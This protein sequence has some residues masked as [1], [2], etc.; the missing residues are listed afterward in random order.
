MSTAPCPHCGNLN[1]TGEPQ[2]LKCGFS[3]TSP[4]SAY[5]PP[6]PQII[7]V[8]KR[9]IWPYILFGLVVLGIIG[10]AISENEKKK[11]A[12][13]SPPSN[14]SA[15]AISAAD[16]Y[17]AYENNEVAADNAYKG[18]LV[19]VTG[20]IES[21]GKDILDTSYVSLGI[22]K[23]SIGSVQCVFSREGGLGNLSKGQTVTITGRC[24]GKMMNVILK[25]CVI[26]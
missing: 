26:K 13:T 23:L 9:R 20:K 21:I 2:C 15:I 18:K 8:K 4:T 17:R 24:E 11:S 12:F 3:L 14:E 19:A 22:G 10:A 5:Q 25:D 1:R 7:Y 6:P 16:L